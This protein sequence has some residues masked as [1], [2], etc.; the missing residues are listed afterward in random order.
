MAQAEIG[1]KIQMFLA[2]FGEVGVRPRTDAC[3]ERAVSY[4][5]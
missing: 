1:V 3:R 5:H 4:R 2:T